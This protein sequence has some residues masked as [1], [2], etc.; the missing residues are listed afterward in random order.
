MTVD[1]K[2]GAVTFNCDGQG[3]RRNYDGEEFFPTLD[4]IKELGWR[5]QQKGARWLHYCPSCAKKVA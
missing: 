1:R 2:T 4:E 5:V 3:C